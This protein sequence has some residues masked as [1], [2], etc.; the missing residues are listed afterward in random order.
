MSS[1][2]PIDHNEAREQHVDDE[3]PPSQEN[4]ADSPQE[5][6]S[7]A[8]AAL[9]PKLIHYRR[10]DVRSISPVLDLPEIP[11]GD[12]ELDLDSILNASKPDPESERVKK[13]ASNVLKLSQENEKLKAEL[14]AMQE[15]LEK[16]EAR[17]EQL[18]RKQQQVMEPPSS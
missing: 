5:A 14:K 8:P 2:L 17:R 12:L 16:A 11:G 3:H 13:R 1:E 6:G 10:S 4:P 9:Q 18:A 15:R 7:V